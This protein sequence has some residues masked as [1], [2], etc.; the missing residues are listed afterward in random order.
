[1]MSGAYEGARF[2]GGNPSPSDRDPSVLLAPPNLTPHDGTGHITS[3]SED[4]FLA[5]FR[6]GTIIPETIMPWGAYG[7]MTDDDLRA[8]FRYLR[9]LTPVDR[10]PG[11]IVTRPGG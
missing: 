8:I 11:P 10:N 2:S 9:T 1:M 6:A 7:R 3:W 5:R 4:Q